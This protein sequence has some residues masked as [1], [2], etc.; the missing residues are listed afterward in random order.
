MVLFILIKEKIHIAITTKYNMKR[1]IK[2]GLIQ[3][4]L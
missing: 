3:Q 1:K 2:Q 4:G